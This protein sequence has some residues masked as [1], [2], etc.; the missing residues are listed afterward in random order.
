MGRRRRGAAAK[1]STSLMMLLIVAS[2]LLAIIPFRV[3]LA[4]GNS[5]ISIFLQAPALAQLTG[6]HVDIDSLGIFLR[7]SF[8]TVFTRILLNRPT[9]T[10]CLLGTGSG[11]CLLP[12]PLDLTKYWA[13]KSQKVTVDIAT[14][15]GSMG[16]L[17]Q[18]FGNGPSLVASSRLTLEV[19][20]VVLSMT[21]SGYNQPTVTTDQYGEDSLAGLN[22]AYVISF[23]RLFLDLFIDPVLITA[24]Y[25]VSADMTIYQAIAM[26][27]EFTFL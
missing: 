1:G 20:V 27:A 4:V 11:G 19:R 21:I 2:A 10:L 3:T 18:P 12:Y 16:G 7:S 13:I 5:T 15:N 24:A 6:T 17:L 8:A 9:G 23:D 14:A 22:P 25:V 26:A